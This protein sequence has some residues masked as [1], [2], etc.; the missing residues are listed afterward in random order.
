MEQPKTEII[1]R[2]ERGYFLPGQ[3]G[4]PGGK[5]K[6]TRNKATTYVDYLAPNA[7]ILM[8]KG[9]EIALG[10]HCNNKEGT[11]I[12]KLF[13]ERILPRVGDGVLNLGI[14]SGNFN[15]K[16]KQIFDIMSDGK[17]AVSDG[18]E[19]IKALAT[20]QSV[21]A[22]EL[23]NRLQKLDEIH[24]VVMATQQENKEL[25]AKIEKLEGHK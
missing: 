3:S 23:E 22:L 2:D 17:V 20:T 7:G 10:A 16:S 19:L 15:E 4:N 8:E 14:I 13:L 1:K 12:L 5:I 11:A 18:S 6:G 24:A 21:S 9:L 25:K